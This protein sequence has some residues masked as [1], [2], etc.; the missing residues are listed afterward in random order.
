MVSPQQ[1]AETLWINQNAYFSM[2]ELD[3]GS[4]VVYEMHEKAN[5]LYLFMISGAA[6]VEDESLGHRDGLGL[7]G[8][9]RYNLQ[10]ESAATVLAM[11]VPY[12]GF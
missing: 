11:E 8:K 12:Q 9:D 10:A 6:I 7:V 1:S 5:G 3:K 2:A 4:T